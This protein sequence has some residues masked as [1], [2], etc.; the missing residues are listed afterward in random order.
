MNTAF[1]DVNGTSIFYRAAGLEHDETI[2]MIHAGICDSRMWQAQLTHYAGQYRVFAP[3]LRGFGQST[4]PVAPFMHHEDIAGLMDTLGIR[5]AWILGCSQGGK[6]ALNLALTH[7]ERVKGLLLVAPAIDGY[8]YEGPPHPLEE[9]L[10][11]AEESGTLELVSEIEVQIWVDAGRR[12]EEIDAAMRQL[13]WEMNMIPLQ[14]PAHLWEQ[15]LPLVPRAIERLENIQQ[16]TLIV[17]GDLDIPAS[18]ERVEILA[19]RLP[20]AQLV[21][22]PDTAHLPSME[23]PVHFHHHVDAFLA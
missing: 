8:Q 9:T 23:A 11:K 21:V 22:M 13:V 20:T 16:P 17:I 4:M 7:P 1:A 18:L 10:E 19:T 2:I 6:I 5:E 15:E 3:D 12:P 14:V